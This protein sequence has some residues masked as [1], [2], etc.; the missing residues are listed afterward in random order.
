MFYRTN[1]NISDSLLTYLHASASDLP[2]GQGMCSFSTFFSSIRP[3][4]VSPPPPQLSTLTPHSLLP[5]FIYTTS[6]LSR[7]LL[8]HWAFRLHFHS[9]SSYPW[10][11]IH[12]THW[13][14]R[15][16]VSL[17]QTCPFCTTTTIRLAWGANHIDRWCKP[18]HHT[19]TI[20]WT[21]FLTGR[22]SYDIL[23]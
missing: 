21:M 11:C 5:S 2:L 19:H 6:P 8:R 4:H 17:S 16:L 14:Y 20:P 23:L 15:P 22:Q 3:S 10:V 9:S 18:R 7:L 13:L 12:D 1:C